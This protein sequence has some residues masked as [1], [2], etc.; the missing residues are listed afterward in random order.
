MGIVDS[1]TSSQPKRLEL[2]VIGGAMPPWPPAEGA[3][4][5]KLLID[6]GVDLNG[7]SNNLVGEGQTALM[8][9]SAQGRV[10]VA[11][12]L[13]DAKANVNALSATWLMRR[14]TSA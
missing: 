13:I 1:Q 7:E 9:A 8:A 14:P 2:I 10:D 5:N 4:S 11:K 3:S 6:S 12:A